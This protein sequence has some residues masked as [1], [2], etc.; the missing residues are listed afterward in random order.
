VDA[1][2]VGQRL[3]PA[4][5]ASKFTPTPRPAAVPK[6][7]FCPLQV[8]NRFIGKV[9]AGRTRAETARRLQRVLKTNGDAPPIEHNRDC[10]AWMWGRK[11]RGRNSPDPVCHLS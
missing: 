9:C 5:E 10:V 8:A 4:V 2:D 11:V 7:P 6:A 3:C 1:G